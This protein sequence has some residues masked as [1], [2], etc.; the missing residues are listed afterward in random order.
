MRL[1]LTSKRSDIRRDTIRTVAGF[2]SA[3]AGIF[4]SNGVH[5]ARDE[6]VMSTDLDCLEA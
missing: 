1:L 3:F 6:A 4:V 5:Q 2:D